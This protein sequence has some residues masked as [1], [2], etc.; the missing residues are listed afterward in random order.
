MLK[1]RLGAF[2]LTAAL[3]MTLT[4]PAYADTQDDIANAQ[5]AQ[6]TAQ[7]NLDN[8]NSTINELQDQKESLQ[9][10]LSQLNAQM[11]QLSDSLTD[12]NNQIDQKNTEIENTKAAVVRAKND[13]ENQYADM[14]TRIQYMYENGNTDLL[15]T[16][17]TSDSISDFINRADEISQ[18]SQYDRDCLNE[19]IETCKSIEQKQTSLENDQASLQALKENAEQ[20]KQEVVDL[21]A[22]TDEKISEYT[23]NISDQELQATNLQEQISEQKTLLSDLQAK[24]AAEE[25]ARKQAEAAAAAAAALAEQKAA[26]EAAAA[27]AAAAAQVET[28]E[29]T[30]S[31]SAAASTASSTDTS[32][33]SASTASAASDTSSSSS[34][35]AADTAAAGGTYL[36]TFMLTAYCPCAKC[37]GRANA[38]TASGVMPTP[39]HTIAMAGVPFGTKLLINGTV[40]TVEDLGTPYGHVDIFMSSHSACLEFG[41]QYAEVYQVG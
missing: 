1:K 17:V 18:I 31:E 35:P 11:T 6:S 34:T 39:N 4:V 3:V 14:E 30:V 37:C 29:S 22:S 23:A 9:T 13:E 19:Y 38:P 28:S 41:V 20:K 24:A 5:A 26:E 36:G 25:A 21:A 40:Y 32:T 7:E 15:S 12:L 8:T 33:S 16:L 27:Q 10:Y 2:I